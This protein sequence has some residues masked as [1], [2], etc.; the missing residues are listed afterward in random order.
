MGSGTGPKWRQG[1]EGDESH[2]G[3][4]GN[5]E[6][7]AS[8]QDRKGQACQVL[9]LPWQQGE[10]RWWLEEDRLGEEQAWKDCEQEK[11]GGWQEGLQK[12]PGLDCSCRKGQEGTWREG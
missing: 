10:D 8:E 4:E 2:E 5:E 12:R 1:H 11:C 6:K 9:R 7:E 3:H